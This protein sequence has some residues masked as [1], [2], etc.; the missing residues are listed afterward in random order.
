M[1]K[2]YRSSTRLRGGSSVNKIKKMLAKHGK[3]L[4]SLPDSE[5]KRLRDLLKKSRGYG[6]YN[7]FSPEQ[8]QK[9]LEY[10]NKMLKQNR[11]KKTNKTRKWMSQFK[12]NNQI[13]QQLKPKPKSV[14]IPG[15]IAASA[16]RT[17]G[18]PE[19]NALIRFADPSN[20]YSNNTNNSWVMVSS[21]N[22]I[23]GKKGKKT[24]QAKK[25]KRAKRSKKQRKSRK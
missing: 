14:Q 10:K 15:Y 23:R 20:K 1:K 2:R 7:S 24:K 16:N 18:D 5:K 11:S 8:K 25:S 22:A 13:N 21:N 19:L 12:T 4:S 9:M 3:P 6:K 17:T